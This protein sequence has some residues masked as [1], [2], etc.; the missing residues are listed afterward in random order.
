MSDEEKVVKNTEDVFENGFVADNAQEPKAENAETNVTPEKAEIK[1]FDETNGEGEATEPTTSKMAAEEPDIASERGSVSTESNDAK[2]TQ[3]QSKMSEPTASK[4]PI[5]AGLSKRM[6]AIIAGA[7]GCIVLGAGVYMVTA[8]P[9]TIDMNKYLEV[10]FDGYDGYGTASKEVDWEKL[11][12]DYSGKIKYKRSTKKAF[13]AAYGD[14]TDGADMED[15]VDP[16]DIIEASVDPEFETDSRKLSNGDKVEISWDVENSY[17]SKLNVKIKANNKTF[18]VKGL[19][20]AKKVDV[21]KDIKVSFAG[22]DGNGTVAI[23][24]KSGDESFVTAENFDKYDGLSNGDKVKLTLTDSQIESLATTGKIPE[25]DSKTYTVSGLTKYAASVSDLS[26]DTIS[27]MKAQAEDIIREENANSSYIGKYYDAGT[28][29]Y[30]GNYVL[31][32]KTA[33]SGGFWFSTNNRVG[34]LYEITLTGTRNEENFTSLNNY[35]ET[36][37]VYYNIY[38]DDITVDS[39]GNTEDNLVNKGSMDSKC[40]NSDVMHQTV[41]GFESL[42]AAK[43]D[44]VDGNAGNYTADWN[45]Q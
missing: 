36:L 13:N 3:P 15:L 32:Q 17:I 33:E 25:K 5:G 39:N 28:P 44:I 18:K 24:T 19:E 7:V 10:T 14:Y 34:L 43:N 22:T 31:K 38:F 11:K 27:K 8:A 26:D 21:F 4:T 1:P 41:Y 42:D 2:E 20:K 23:D 45:V 40:F 16:V 6:K 35:G 12:A 30:V 29:E 37:N 9:K